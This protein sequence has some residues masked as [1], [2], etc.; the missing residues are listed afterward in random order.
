[1][2]GEFGLLSH[3]P[4]PITHHPNT[5]TPQHP[6]IAM[7]GITKRFGPVVANDHVDFE[8]AWGE[9]HALVGENGAGKSTLMSIL[10]GLYR[11]DSGTIEIDGT[12]VRFR[13]PRDAIEHGIGMVYQHF[14]L[15]EPFTVA[16]NVVLGE[17]RST[18]DLGLPRVER[19]LA[20]LSE[21]YGLGVDPKARI[22]QLSV[23][24][25]QRVEIL[26]LLY[27]GA[28]ILVFDEPTA[29][30]T[31]QEAASLIHTLR[32]LAAQGFSVI[33]ISHKLDEVME[34][35]D[36][37]SILRRGQIVATTAP[38]ETDRRT[39][40]RLMVGRELAAM[41]EHPSVEPRDERAPG[42]TVLALRGVGAIGEKGLPALRDIDLEVR[43]GE[44]LGIAGVAGNGQSELAEVVTGLRRVST[45]T[46]TIAGRDMT[47]R[48]AAEVARAGVAHIPEDRL[49]TGL[50]GGMDLSA[51]A[52]LREYGR[53]P[54]SSGPFLA[55][56]QV[57]TFTDRLISDHDVKAPGR[58]AKLRTLSGGNQQKL[59]LGRELAGS[60]RL[61]VAVHPTRGV[62]IG[63]TEAI[64]E[65]LRR[66]RTSGAATLLISEDLDELLALSDRIAVLFDGQVMGVLPARGADPEQIGLLMAGV[67]P[68]T[69]ADTSVETSAHG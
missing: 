63:A 62:D 3:H 61:I 58:W 54:L 60:P 51:N 15:V 65:E 32:G 8:A 21:R 29:V 31:P 42:E 4:S 13:S 28:R 64:H 25:Q 52:I 48:P 67:S 6:A 69:R 50:I 41:V 44:T 45:G 20:E 36:C 43:A 7:R 16:E 14:M 66:Q 24:E 34:V 18:V 57:N 46:V 19:E 68:D 35:A 5:P 56:Q 10:A 1:V 59:L 9:V 11:P 12:P 17:R 2:E 55:G 26:R 39:L 27:L 49:A 30:L 37:I 22:W 47:N 53:P 40:A 33:F 38:S 23:G